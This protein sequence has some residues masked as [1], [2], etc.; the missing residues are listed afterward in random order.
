MNKMYP[1]G[2]KVSDRATGVE[3]EILVWLA[4]IMYQDY[5]I[6]LL[7][8]FKRQC[9]QLGLLSE[10]VL[11]VTKVFG[12]LDACNIGIKCSGRLGGGINSTR[13]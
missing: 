13:L 4:S 5:C 11:Y 7:F 12:K 1:R 9:Y 10:I 2:R 3:N 6:I 8:I